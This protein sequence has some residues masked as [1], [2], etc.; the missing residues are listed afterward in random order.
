MGEE[1]LFF[2]P[3]VFGRVVGLFE[4]RDELAFLFANFLKGSLALIVVFG[5]LIYQAMLNR[6]IWGG[7][8]LLVCICCLGFV[9]VTLD[10]VLRPNLIEF[11]R[12]SGLLT[13]T[14]RELGVK[15]ID[16]VAVGEVIVE[17]RP[18]GCLPASLGLD[19]INV[20]GHNGT[21]C[22]QHKFVFWKKD[23]EK[24]L[25]ITGEEVEG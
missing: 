20:F 14:S 8:V 25:K 5:F 2:E 4:C 6:G 13:L 16:E 12:M 24:L 18:V 15:K 11:D 17:L 22:S 1:R 21:S 10:Y 9:L 23:T 7:V 3:L 19:V